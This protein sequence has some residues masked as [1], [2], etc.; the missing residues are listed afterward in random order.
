MVGPVRARGGFVQANGC[1][2]RGFLLG[3]LIGQLLAEWL[4]RG[5]RPSLLAAFDA[6]RF[7]GTDAR[8][9]TGDYYAGYAKTEQ[10]A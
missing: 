7:D 9:E 4:D 5:E 6:N 10:R 2:G 1:N 8:V 3:P